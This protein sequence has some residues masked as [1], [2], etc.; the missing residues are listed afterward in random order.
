VDAAS[1]AR[2]DHV[3]VVT[4]GA[5]GIGLEIAR[6]LL[7]AGDRVAILGRDAAAL[8]DA[9]AALDPSGRRVLAAVCDV[10]DPEA[11]GEAVGR[12]LRAYGRIDVLVANSGIA[13]P[14]APLWE[15]PP[16]RWRQA[17]ETNLIGAALCARAVLPHMIARRSGSIVFVGSMTGKRPLW[18]RTSYAAS[19]TALIG[20][21]R[22]LAVEAGPYGVRVNL[23]SPGPVE[24][25]RIERVFAAQAAARGITAERARAEMLDGTPLGRL[26]RPADVAA[27]VA[28]LAGDGAAA[29]TGEDVNVSAGLVMY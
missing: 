23:V 15:T 11:I 1:H 13:G 3:A 22:T 6:A 7:A 19:K 26:V 16:E 20:L 2:D 9:A 21:V 4:G 27:A 29:I 24:G 17:I 12:T 25:E 14:T 5:R 8:K 18:G 10:R 28:F